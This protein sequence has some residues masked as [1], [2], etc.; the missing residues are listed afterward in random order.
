ML[1]SVGVPSWASPSASS[2]AGAAILA[3]SALAAAPAVQAQS[4]QDCAAEGATCRVKG[5]AR[6]RFGAQGQY[7]Y[8]TV[9]DAVACHVKT[10]GDPLP[11]VPKRCEVLLASTALPALGATMPTAGGA[12]MDGPWLSCSQEGEWCHVPRPARVRF[13]A[14]DRFAY[15]DTDVPVE[16]SRDV[17]GDPMPGEYKRCEYMPL[18]AGVRGAS[19]V[20]PQ[21]MPGTAMQD[22]TGVW[23]ACAME[24][25]TCHVH[26]NSTV[27]FGVQRQWASR[28]V[29][30]PVACTVKTFGDPAPGQP[31]AC[32]VRR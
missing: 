29:S 12:S 18:P 31:K 15:R 14:G 30:Q 2:L 32:Y 27:R 10:F 8:S 7:A 16:C 21:G 1:S 6:V 9:R 13:G 11:G 25:G 5:Q 24:G 3:L 17:F 23:D 19:G 26:G 22:A 20:T 4:W 28:A